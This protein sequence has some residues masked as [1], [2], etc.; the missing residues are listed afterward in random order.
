MYVV[1][2]S[3][4][5]R[6][7]TSRVFPVPPTALPDALASLAALRRNDPALVRWIED[8]HPTLTA[9][10]HVA[11]FGGPYIVTRSRKT[12]AT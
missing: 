3:F 9:D 2:G 8:G 1:G 5:E 6:R 10:E 11:R 4:D 7:N 12:S